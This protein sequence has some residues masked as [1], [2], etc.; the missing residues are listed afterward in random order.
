MELVKKMILN[1]IAT[2]FFDGIYR[3]QS[4]SNTSQPV[5]EAKWHVLW[6]SFKSPFVTASTHL[7]RTA[8]PVFRPGATQIPQ[9][10][11]PVESP[12]RNLFQGFQSL[13]RHVM[14]WHLNLLTLVK[15]PCSQNF[16]CKNHFSLPT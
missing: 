4:S 1:A 9:S 5:I 14:M 12:T 2:N 8:Q 7:H 10:I 15:F 16:E 11:T 6:D 3:Q 13:Q